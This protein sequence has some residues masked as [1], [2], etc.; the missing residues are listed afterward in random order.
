MRVLR[1][2]LFCDR[3]SHGASTYYVKALSQVWEGQNLVREDLETSGGLGQDRPQAMEILAELCEARSPVLPR[4]V[5]D[6]VRDITGDPE[7]RLLGRRAAAGD[8]R[9]RRGRVIYLDPRY[10]P[11]TQRPEPAGDPADGQAG[12]VEMDSAGGPNGRGS[13]GGGCGDDDDGR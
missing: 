10:L 12:R 11:D 2:G 3:T 9:H 1:Y 8:P 7:R 4:H 13:G 5:V 6:I